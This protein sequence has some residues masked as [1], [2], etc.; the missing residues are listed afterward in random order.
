[1][2]A[3]QDGVYFYRGRSMAG[4]F[5]DGDALR[6]IP[7]AHADLRVGDVVVYRKPGASEGR[8]KVVHRVVRIIPG[9]VILCGDYNP[10][11]MVEVVLAEDILG[12]VTHVE[13]AGRWRRVQN[14]RGGQVRGLVLH[15]RRTLRRWTW[16]HAQRIGGPTYRRFKRSGLARRIWKPA[17]T[18]ITL[19]TDYGPSIK[20]LVRGR[21]VAQWWPQLNHFEIRRPYDLVITRPEFQHPPYA[22]LYQPGAE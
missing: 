7:V 4:T 6:T 13:R 17:I 22:D 8:D 1:M 12:R 2:L 3:V 11:H 18:Q 10:V 14:G 9:G 21:T 19:Q 5:R 16:K 20:Y 15:A